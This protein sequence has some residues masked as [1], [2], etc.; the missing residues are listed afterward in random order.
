MA[1]IHHL[2]YTAGW[3]SGRPGV[4]SR[5]KE[6]DYHGVLNTIDAALGGGFPGRFLYMTSSGVTR[7]SLWTVLL[8]AYKGNTLL[9]RR[10]AEDA[11]R[12]SGLA[13]TIVRTGVLL[14]RQGGRRRIELTQEPLP[15]SPRYR[16]ARADVAEAFVA[17]LEHPA[18]I[19]TTFEI[20]WGR[21]TH[22]VPWP[23]LLCRLIPDRDRSSPAS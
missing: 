8:N 10:Q 13:Y 18:T 6:T 21:G 3:R 1:G 12:G 2:V 16:I 17:A 15:L 14:N 4:A 23:D 20:A 11:L 9:W 7:P 22:R 19:R 5:V